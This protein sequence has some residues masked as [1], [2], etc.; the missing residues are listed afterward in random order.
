M[1]S[2]IESFKPPETLPE[3]KPELNLL[4]NSALNSAIGEFSR[5]YVGQKS[6][7]FDRYLKNLDILCDSV[8]DSEDNDDPYVIREQ[9]LDKGTDTY[10][11]SLAPLSKINT[12]D[13]TKRRNPSLDLS[14][15]SVSE[16][17]LTVHSFNNGEANPS[18]V[19]SSSGYK[20]D[21]SV[22]NFT[23]SDNGKIHISDRLAGIGLNIFLDGSAS[24]YLK[25]YIGS[26]DFIY[27]KP[28]VPIRDTKNTQTVIQY[29]SGL[30]L[31]RPET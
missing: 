14:D 24:A 31:S 6:K 17:H 21:F 12:S 22:T 11:I 18:Q 13:L 15:G 25:T 7:S 10:Y 20:I 19:L 2:G 26:G 5:S 16:C 30:G 9:F 28:P 4:L 3:L 23:R 27:A 29:L 8:D 1:E